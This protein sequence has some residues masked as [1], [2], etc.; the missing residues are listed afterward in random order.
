[1]PDRAQNCQPLLPDNIYCIKPLSSFLEVL[2]FLS[3]VTPKALFT[4]PMLAVLALML[5]IKSD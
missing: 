3:P 2:L 4:G 1:M 5:A